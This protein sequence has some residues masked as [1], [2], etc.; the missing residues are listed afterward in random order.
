MTAR[1]SMLYVRIDVVIY[2]QT[3]S[4]VIVLRVLHVA[5]QWPAR[6]D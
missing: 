6:S 4:A 5:Q 2:A 3:A 1:T